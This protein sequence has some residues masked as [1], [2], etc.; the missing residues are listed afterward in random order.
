MINHLSC[1]KAV[2]YDGNMK[3]NVRDRFFGE[4]IIKTDS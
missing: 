2:E 4:K 1:L 3:A